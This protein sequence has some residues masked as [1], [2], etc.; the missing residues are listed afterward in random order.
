MEKYERVLYL[1][2]VGDDYFIRIPRAD[3]QHIEKSVNKQI[4]VTIEDA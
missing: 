2:K 4:K 3:H 1:R